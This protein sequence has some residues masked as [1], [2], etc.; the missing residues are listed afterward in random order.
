MVFA[1]VVP[2]IMKVGEWLREP[3]VHFLG[4]GAL[5]FTAAAWLAPDTGSDRTIRVTRQSVIDHLQSRA[6]LYDN[7]SFE[8][9]L[10]GM[11]VEERA[12]L[13]RDA[14]AEEAL[15]REGSALDLAGADPLVRRRVVQQMRQLLLEERAGEVAVSDAEVEQY[16]RTNTADY[17]L[18]ER[19]RF[20]HVFFSKEV[21]SGS[22]R[23]AAEAAVMQLNSGK[24]PFQQAGEHG[25]RFLYQT[26][27]ADADAR[28]LASQFGNGFAKGALEL[29]ASSRWQGPLESDHGWHVLGVSEHAPA[30][31]PP[32]GE[33]RARV[34]EDALAAKRVEAANEAVDG[35]LAQYD[36]RVEDSLEQP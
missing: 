10:A 34:R 16:Y 22:A 19:L 14:A 11:S 8:R 9:L 23:A 4:A 1:R 36:V 17:G 27:Y 20:A 5:L 6:Q 32:L 18:S 3:L 26:H 7:D 31:L 33:I 21:R 24:I 28:I 2:A 30:E 15:Y 13:V 12:A 25:D 29:Q 35:L